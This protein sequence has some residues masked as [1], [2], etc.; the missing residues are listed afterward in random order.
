MIS[1]LSQK[2]DG[3]NLVAAAKVTAD[4][5]NAQRLGYILDHVR[6]RQLAE[7][8][9]LWVEKQSPSVAPLHSHLRGHQ[10]KENRRWH[11]LVDQP[12]DIDT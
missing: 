7:P 2:I 9:R 1:E 10:A 5:P 3:K 11:V 4:V 8:L 6:A 12:L